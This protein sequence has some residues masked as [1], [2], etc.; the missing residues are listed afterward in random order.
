MQIVIYYCILQAG[1]M[2]GNMFNKLPAI[3]PYDDWGWVTNA[4]TPLSPPTPRWITKP[5]LSRKNH[6]E[7]DNCGCK[8][9]ECKPTCL[10]A[11]IGQICTMR[12]GCHGL[13]THTV[14][15]RTS[16]DS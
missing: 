13:C 9:G 14:N 3:P 12:C 16:S 6:R 15:M 10:C 8:T 2:W 11:T 7:L 4:E 1:H 5:V